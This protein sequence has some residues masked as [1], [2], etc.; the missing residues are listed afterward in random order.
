[1][2]EFEGSAGGNI[3]F[4]QVCSRDLRKFGKCLL[5][6]KH[7]L[8]SL[9]TIASLLSSDVTIAILTHKNDSKIIFVKDLKK[10]SCSRKKDPNLFLK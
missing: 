10:N 8:S 5:A 2:A 7:K 6:V 9:L 4:V 1:M 3:N